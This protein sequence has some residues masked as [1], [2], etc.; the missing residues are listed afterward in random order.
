VN[1]VAVAQ[2][3]EWANNRDGRSVES[4][5]LGFDLRSRGANEIRYIEV[6]GRKGVGPVAL[7]ANEW[8]K[9]ARFGKEYWLYVVYECSTAKPRLI[10]I[11]DPAARL[12]VTE[13]VF[14]ASHF[15]VNVGEVTKHG[16]PVTT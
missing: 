7:T 3:Y 1:C 6:K 2:E 12:T 13:D 9:A 16:V 10:E 11:R 15:L 4:A 8:I 5:N 14:T